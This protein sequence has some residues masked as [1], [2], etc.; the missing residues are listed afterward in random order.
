MARR[1]W[2]PLGGSRCDLEPRLRGLGVRRRDGL[3]ARPVD[4]ARFGLLFLPAKWNGR[5]I[6]SPPPYDPAPRTI[7]KKGNCLEEKIVRRSGREYNTVGLDL[8]HSGLTAPLRT[9]NKKKMALR[10]AR[11]CNRCPISS[12]GRSRSGDA[13]H[14]RSGHSGSPISSATQPVAA[15]SGSTKSRR[16]RSST[17]PGAD[18]G[19]R[20]PALSHRARVDRSGDQR[21]PDRR[22][23]RRH[24]R[25]AL[26]HRPRVDRV[27]ADR[28]R[29]RR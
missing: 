15:G 1:L 28:A 4:F 2:Q 19:L 17:S 12:S 9:P 16:P 24:T 3:N 5:R 22:L 18:R 7:R 10:R 20:A 23:E 21:A 8:C 14:E 26:S 6:V 25:P 27:G 11:G 13:G 29:D